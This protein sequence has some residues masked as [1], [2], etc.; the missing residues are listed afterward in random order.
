[1]KIQKAY[2]DRWF[3]PAE[4]RIM[5]PE[6]QKLLDDF[7]SPF[8]IEL[9]ELMDDQRFLFERVERPT[10][11]GEETVTEKEPSKEVKEGQIPGH[12]SHD[13]SS[14]VRKAAT[15]AQK[16]HKENKSENENE[17]NDKT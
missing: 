8:N 17:T 10:E 11:A 7:Y 15:E 1:M 16:T 3:I 9:A 6:T 13:D 4:D 2:Y 12:K 14:K 5:L